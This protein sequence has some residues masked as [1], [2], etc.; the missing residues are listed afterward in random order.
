LYFVTQTQPDPD[1]QFARG[2][3]WARAVRPDD[4][5]A[6]RPI[7]YVAFGLL[8]LVLVAFFIA[9]LVLPPMFMHT[10]IIRGIRSNRPGMLAAGI[11]VAAIYVMFLYAAGKRLMA[12][13]PASN[14]TDDQ[15]KS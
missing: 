5:K 12:P 4:E 11:V 13:R 3:P 14:E 9:A 8:S 1:R 2:N 15:D 7:L 10:L 6:Q